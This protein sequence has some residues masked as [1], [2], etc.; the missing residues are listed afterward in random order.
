MS[1]GHCAWSILPVGGANGILLGTASWQQ[2]G[3][4]RV[5]HLG[6]LARG[7]PTD[8]AGCPRPG[9]QAL[10]P[11]PGRRG[12]CGAAPFRQALLQGI[13]GDS[14]TLRAELFCEGPGMAASRSS[15][16]RAGDHSA[17]SSSGLAVFPLPSRSMLTGVGGVDMLQRKYAGKTRRR[18]ALNHRGRRR[19]VYCEQSFAAMSEDTHSRGTGQP[20]GGAAFAIPCC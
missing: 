19:A 15:M 4:T 3:Y 18:G 16:R 7:R 8:T 10:S 12:A 1:N 17:F 2:A 11:G 13:G 20:R 6:R 5:G 14:R 9:A